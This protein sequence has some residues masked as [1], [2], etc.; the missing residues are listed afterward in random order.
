M[1]SQNCSYKNDI[2]IRKKQRKNATKVCDLTK[3]SKRS[4]NC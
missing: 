2:E 3:T 1:L 4:V